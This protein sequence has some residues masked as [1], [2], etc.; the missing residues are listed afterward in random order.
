[1]DFYYYNK[2]QHYKHLYRKLKGGS[3]H[4]QENIII[5]G[6]CK[7]IDDLKGDIKDKTGE[8]IGNIDIYERYIN[9][10]LPNFYP[11][12]PNTEYY[13]TITKR[14]KIERGEKIYEDNV[15]FKSIFSQAKEHGYLDIET[16][17]KKLHMDMYRQNTV[18]M[19]LVK[20]IHKASK[21]PILGNTI[22]ICEGVRTDADSDV[23]H[24]VVSKVYQIVNRNWIIHTYFEK[25][26]IDEGGEL[27]PNII[28][29]PF[30]KIDA[31]NLHSHMNQVYKIQNEILKKKYL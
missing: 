9:D 21:N 1:M 15:L 22:V 28:L 26:E 24:W 25:G 3:H 20:D 16:L 18:Y 27:D 7:N 30:E 8:P 11:I 29:V 19:I 6:H 31:N 2:Y 5:P 10:P 13:Y 17:D 4:Q 14:S 23:L 12:K